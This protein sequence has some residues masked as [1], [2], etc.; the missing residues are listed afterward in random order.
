MGSISTKCRNVDTGEIDP[1][2]QAVVDMCEAYAE[3]SPSGEGLK[4]FGAV[5]V[6]GPT[7]LELTFHA[8]HVTVARKGERLLHRDW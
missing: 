3:I 2:A 8:G 4:I 7:W 6:N 1:R 5:D